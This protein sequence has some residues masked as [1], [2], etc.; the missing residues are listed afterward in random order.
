MSLRFL[1]WATRK[2]E[3]QPSEIGSTN[4]TV[5]Q[6]NIKSSVWD[7]FNLKFIKYLNGDIR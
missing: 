5:F 6:G 7:M 2:T 1:T 4:R 3:L